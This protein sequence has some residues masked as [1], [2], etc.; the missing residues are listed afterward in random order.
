MT[1]RPRKQRKLN[2]DE[3]TEEPQEDLTYNPDVANSNG[4]SYIRY[5]IIDKKGKQ[6]VVPVRYSIRRQKRGVIVGEYQL[7]ME[8]HILQNETDLEYKPSM[9]EGLFQLSHSAQE[10]RKILIDQA[11][12][13]E[14]MEK[15]KVQAGDI[16]EI[17]ALSD[18]QEYALLK[19]KKDLRESKYSSHSY[20][21]VALKINKRMSQAQ[22]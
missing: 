9:M 11:A 4:A 16:Q 14:N 7:E 22:R 19:V 5:E 8:R 21:A 12:K 3:I 17:V 6:Y 1:L 2:E 20:V 18:S 13:K 10:I 15:Q